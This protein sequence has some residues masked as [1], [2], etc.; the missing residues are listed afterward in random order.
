MKKRK[1]GK[2]NL[3]VSEIGFG[4]RSLGG[5]LT[6]NGIGTTFANLTFTNACK[7]INAAINS[8]IT[9]FDTADSYS[10]GNSEKRLGEIIKGRRD[11]LQIFTKAGA[12]PSGDQNRT[13]E[14]D[15]SYNHLLAAVD[16]SLK[17]LHIE[18]VDLFQTHAVPTSELEIEDV[19]K[20]FDKMKA[21]NKI[22]YCGIS[23]GNSIQK[24]IEILEYDFIDCIQ[25]SL[26]M[27]NKD[28]LEEL[29][30][31]AKKKRIGIII[32]RPLSEGFLSS[33]KIKKNRKKTDI[34]YRYSKNKLLEIS[35]KINKLNFLKKEQFRLSQIA[36]KYVLSKKEISTCIIS[37]NTLKQLK[38]NISST[39]IP[40]KEK[41][42]KKIDYA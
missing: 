38:A 30:P 11:D 29:I 9:V 19:S 13:F 21:E 12:I 1:L 6:I 34:R 22:R 2:T 17:R 33:F 25:V 36:L 31:K 35:K 16:R 42:L 28:A 39:E 18:Y 5:K 27:I 41:I 14:I 26:S 40:M 4:C 24:G 15:L 20:A 10:F 37:S 8:G 7:L 23:V 32:N 3:M